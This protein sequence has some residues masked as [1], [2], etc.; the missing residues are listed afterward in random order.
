MGTQLPG[1]AV[2]STVGSSL[3][4]RVVTPVKLGLPDLIAWGPI[5]ARAAT[6]GLLGNAVCNCCRPV[7]VGV[8]ELP[9]EL[10]A[11]PCLKRSRLVDPKNQTLSF[12]MGPPM[13]PPKRLST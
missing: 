3:T 10:G 5:E 9:E 11:A 4:S 6:P 2:Q 8:K 7:K 13:V 1:V 12:L